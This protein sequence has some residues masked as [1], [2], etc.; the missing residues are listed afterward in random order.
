MDDS[1]ALKHELSGG[2]RRLVLI[3]SGW[4]GMEVGATART[5]G[6][7]VTILERDPIPLANAIGDELGQMFAELH[8]EN[9]VVLRTS[10]TVNRIA[11]EHGK[12]SGVVLDDGEEIP[13][14]IVLIGVGVVPNVALADDAG[15]M[16]EN[17]IV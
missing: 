8:R 10:V 4:I 16:T 14:G 9:G 1:T 3:G 7:D 5:L 11:G 12:V 13:A 2:G 6:N 17:G 15:I